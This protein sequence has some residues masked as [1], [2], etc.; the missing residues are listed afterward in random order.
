MGRSVIAPTTEPLDGYSDAKIPQTLRVAL[1][2]ADGSGVTTYLNAMRL[3]HGAPL[4]DQEFHEMKKGLRAQVLE[5][6]R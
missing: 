6:I 2:G 5:A 1:I 4:S 3:M